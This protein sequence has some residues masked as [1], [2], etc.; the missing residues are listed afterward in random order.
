MSNLINRYWKTALFAVIGAGV[1]YAYWRF[2]GC[3]TGTCPL[4][5]NWT[6]STLMGGLVGLLAAPAWKKNN[7]NKITEND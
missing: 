4:T 3:S 6:S 2:V 5:S 7:T 1:G